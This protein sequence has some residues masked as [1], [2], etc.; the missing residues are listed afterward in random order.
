MPRPRR[1]GPALRTVTVALDEPLIDTLDALAPV[2]P[3]N[4]SAK[5]RG[6]LRQAISSTT[7]GGSSSSGSGA[8]PDKSSP[9]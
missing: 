8:G 2:G 7:S 9:A 1:P 4:R 5:I 6:L 3:R